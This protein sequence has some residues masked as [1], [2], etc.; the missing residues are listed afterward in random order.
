MNE[1]SALVVAVRYHNSAATQAPPVTSKHIATAK[2][3]GHRDSEGECVAGD[4]RLRFYQRCRMLEGRDPQ[5][6]VG[7]GGPNHAAWHAT[8]GE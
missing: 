5:E 6:R 8:A 2:S 1:E 3:E 7:G 4:E